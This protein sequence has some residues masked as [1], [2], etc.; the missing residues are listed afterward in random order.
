MGYDATLI[1]NP[2]DCRLFTPE[3]PARDKLHTIFS[4]CQGDLA[5]ELLAAVCENRGWELRA[6]DNEHR[7]LGL[8]ADMNE[9][10]VVVGLG[11]SAMEGM[12]CGRAVLVLDSRAYTPYAMDGLVT[13]ENVQSLLECNLSGRRF[14]REATLESVS[15][16]L[17][18]Y[19]PELGLFGRD[20]A[21]TN[22]EV[23]RQVDAYLDLASSIRRSPWRL[24]R[25]FL[26]R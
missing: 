15:A 22:F 26:G 3:R 10:D 6:V 16:E 8:E 19:R 4:L 12:A 20:F 23:G 11:R 7:G 24:V 2:I 13:S 17:D 21:L 5:N 9:A 14:A 1:R 25:G 18:G